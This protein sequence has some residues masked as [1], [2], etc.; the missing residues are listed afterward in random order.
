MERKR[1]FE[2]GEWIDTFTGQIGL[3]ISLETLDCIRNRFKEGHRPGY[4]FS[5][6]CCHNPDYV[7]QIPVFFEDGTFDVMRA[8]NI[9]K[10]S[11]MPEEKKE[12][13]QR[14]MQEGE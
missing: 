5:P 3:V 9:R 1:L 6:G 14:M 10:K 2:A 8:I 13:I 4:Y 12:L 7:T 11:D